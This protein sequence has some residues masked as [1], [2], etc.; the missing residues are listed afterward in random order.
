MVNTARGLAKSYGE[1]LRGCNVR[2][3]NPEKAEGFS[4][5]LQSGPL[6]GR[7]DSQALMSGIESRTEEPAGTQNPV[8]LH[9]LCVM[10]LTTACAA[11]HCP[12]VARATVM[13]RGRQ[14]GRPSWEK[15]MDEKDLLK[16]PLLQGL[17]A[18]HRAELLGLLNNSNL[19]EKL[20][21]CLTQH[22]GEADAACASEE[23][24]FEKEVHSWN[25]QKLVFSRSPKE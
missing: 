2:N 22:G 8:S 7:T 1:R 23:R 18:M 5:E 16:C 19:R 25:P 14:D 3:M 6:G 10:L 24:N 20:E 17:D 13:E 4:P 15:I 11:S 9:E 21:A 12:M